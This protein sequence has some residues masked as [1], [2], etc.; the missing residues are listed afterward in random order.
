MD[1]LLQPFESRDVVLIMLSVLIG[2]LIGIEREYRNKSAGLRTFILVSFGS[3]LFTILSLKIGLANPDRLAANIITGI[4]FLGA[5][6]I[7]KEDNKVSGITTATTIWAAAS[8]GMCVGAG[9]I[10]LAFIGV[11]LVLAILALLTYLQ[12]YIDN[13]HKIK[14]Y[15]LQTSSEADFEHTEQLIRRMGFKAVIVSQRYNKESLNTI[16]RLTGNVTKHREFVET[17]RRDRQVVAYQY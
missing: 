7:F 11:G 13:Y 1:N 15:E 10:F 6:V 3:C 12:T 14:D 9:Y 8:L 5:G 4:G 17:V 2:L 16:W